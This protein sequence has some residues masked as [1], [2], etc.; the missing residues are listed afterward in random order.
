MKLA[1]FSLFDD[2]VDDVLDTQFNDTKTLYPRDKTVHQLFAEQTAQTPDATAVIFG[3][4]RLTYA[5]LDK[6]AN[7]FA[8]FLL[9]TGAV[10]PESYIGLLL[11][12]S[13]DVIVAMLGCLKAGCAY[14]PLNTD[15]PLA[16]I[17]Y[18]LNDTRAPILVSDRQ[19]IR[20]L[21]RL[22]WE[23]K[24]L[25][26][27]LCIDSD[28][29]YGEIE[30]ETEMM[31]RSM[32]A[33]I[34]DTAADDIMG[35]GWKSSYTGDWL[36][37]EV[38]DGYG[39]N[40]RD[41]LAP[42]VNVESRLLEIGCASGI[43]M[44]RLAPLVGRYVGVDLSQGIIDWARNERDQRG[45]DQVDLHCLAAHEIEQLDAPAFDGVIIN[46]VIQSFPGH[47]YLR[48]VIRQSIEKLGE[49][50]WLFL[51]NLWDQDRKDA[52]VESLIAYQ[53]AHP[54]AQTKIDRTGELFVSRSY[55][56]D[57][58]HDFP[59]IVEFNYSEMLGDAESELSEFGFDALI[60]VDKSAT[61]NTQQSRNKR[62]FDRRA[63]QSQPTNDPA[64]PASV[65]QLAY[66]MYTSGST[67]QPKGVMVEHRPIVRLVRNTNYITLDSDTV[68]L[69]TGS[70]AFDAATLE[71]WGA[72]LNGGKLCLA[73]PHAILDYRQLG[74]LIAQHGVTTLWLTASLFN[75]LVSTE[76]GV[77]AG[78][79]TL[80]IGGEKLSVPHV[81]Q[82]RRAY[83]QLQ[84]ING[85]GP[86]ENTT[87]TTC[88]E[89]AEVQH[90]DVPIGRPIAN[91]TVH[92]LDSQ[93]RPVPVGTV[94]EL[95][96]GGDGLA[97]GYLNDA[98]LT[99]ARF[100]TCDVDGEQVRIYRTGDLARWQPDGTVIFMGRKDDQV[101]IRGFRIEPD[102]IAVRLLQYDKVQTAVVLTKLLRG[103]KTLVAYVVGDVSAEN[104]RAHL[105]IT[106]PDYMLPSHF[107]LLDSLPLN[108]NGKADR[109]ALPD[110]VLAETAVHLP[111]T[112]T[113]K[114]IAAIWAEILERKQVGVQE[115][116]FDAG[117][118]S[119]KVTRLIALIEQR[120]QVTIPLAT[121]FNYPTV[122]EQAQIVLDA[123][124]F[125]DQLVDQ[126][127]VLLNADATRTRPA[128]FAFPPGTGDVLGYIQL[129][130]LANDVDFYAFN[131]ITD[132]GRVHVYADSIMA[133]SAAP[134][135]LFG[136]S[137]GGNLAFHVAQELERR[138]KRVAKIIM[139]DSSRRLR[140]YRASDAEIAEVT[141]QYMAHE[142]VQ[143][144]LTSALLREKQAQIIRASFEWIGQ[145][146]DGGG[147]SADIHVLTAENEPLTAHDEAGNVIAAVSAWADVTTG[148]VTI[149]QGHGTHNE[150]LYPPHLEENY[151]L[152]V[153]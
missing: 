89:I 100:T 150:M 134:Y 44:F 18:M 125:G 42:H 99:A 86:T 104:L 132:A 119:L 152:F 122:R 101:K 35:G 127:M 55:L 109:H 49:T 137:S 133:T 105:R 22:Q 46:S 19:H 103:E 96:A 61:G 113:E 114:Q 32:W 15:F 36:S 117:G 21:N 33:Y 153:S 93:L 54:E 87:F 84:L 76:I 67:G 29:I 65:G 98:T 83:P 94:G 7:Q 145:V 81:N 91:T 69:Q 34:A 78:L 52:F 106:L 51:G 108:Q 148:N 63:L 17:K 107:V 110:P 120:L 13:L 85:Y 136:Y 115:N 16:R 41:K 90:G 97:R 60:R 144:Y 11:D 31:D 26:V 48:D 102:E 130:E 131:F 5:E 56:E 74:S 38:M 50:G 146:V 75:Q 141:A 43:S 80:L 53:K 92:I 70:L 62:Q 4:E 126:S 37:R 58:Q 6:Q 10:Q 140:P 66:L 71:I 129:A 151:R 45:L 124:Q 25:G 116:F 147:I 24:H 112:E 72:L 1:D 8:H 95:C 40:I 39:D 135:T 9:A 128:L 14:L 3:D 73:P 64:T 68:I 118:H 30:G 2:D 139:I 142:S 28:D 47:N 149:E 88:H 143:P 27:V 138:G 111:Q 59:E 57:L 23:C 20:T 121:V 77:F 79:Q 123:L 82:V 12:R